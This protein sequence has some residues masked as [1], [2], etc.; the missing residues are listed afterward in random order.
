MSTTDWSEAVEIGACVKL[1]A[2]SDLQRDCSYGEVHL[3][4]VVFVS[5]S[6]RRPTSNPTPALCRFSQVLFASV[7]AISVSQATTHLVVTRQAIKVR[8]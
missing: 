8:R 1:A 2:H 4:R 6:A 5:R 7:R 3:L